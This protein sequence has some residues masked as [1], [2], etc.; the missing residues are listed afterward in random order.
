MPGRRD[1][2]RTWKLG[3][4]VTRAVAEA[5]P[6]TLCALFSDGTEDFLPC[7]L[8]FPTFL[9]CNIIFY[10]EKKPFNVINQ[11]TRELVTRLPA[12]L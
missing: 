12:G 10:N 3:A 9:Q 2:H 5:A 8:N 1:C 7:F 6:G 11:K 4:W